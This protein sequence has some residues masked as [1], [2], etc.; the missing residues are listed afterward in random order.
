MKN[1]FDDEIN[2]TKTELDQFESEVKAVSTRFAEAFESMGI[3]PGLAA[4]L[5]PAIY[6]KMMG[7]FVAIKTI[8]LET[9]KRATSMLPAI[10][11]DLSQDF[12]DHL[13]STETH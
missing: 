11:E 9:A 6:A 2:P 13:D 4:H 3:T 8:E 10:I 5:M 1:I 12:S 7:S